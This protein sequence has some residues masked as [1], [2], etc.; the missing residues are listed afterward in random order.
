MKDKTKRNL[1]LLGGGVVCVALLI[2]IGMRFQAPP[3]KEDVL[4]PASSSAPEANPQP[5]DASN[6]T[7]NPQ[8]T[9]A[10]KLSVNPQPID[11]N[12]AGG[13][14]PQDKESSGS[15]PASQIPDQTDQME[16]Q[17][18]PDVVK[19]TPPPKDALPEDGSTPEIVDHDAVTTPP[20]D[21]TTSGEP[22]HGDTKDGKIYVDGFGWIDA[23]GDSQGTVVDGEGDINKQVGTMD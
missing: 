17:I 13:G 4:P 7:V 10:T 9:D 19:P 8:P 6:P 20:P 1:V 11:V 14:S 16:Q 2:G 12:G 21:S 5:I 3:S 22:Q 18:Q 23:I 15:A